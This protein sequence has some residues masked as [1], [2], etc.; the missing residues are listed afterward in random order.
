[1]GTKTEN[2]EVNKELYQ[3]LVEKI[4]LVEDAEQQAQLVKEYYNKIYTILD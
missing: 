4:A 3:E 1:M 2:V